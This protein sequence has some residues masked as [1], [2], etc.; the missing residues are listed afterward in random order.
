MG[1]SHFKTQKSVREVDRHAM[2]Y[3]CHGTTLDGWLSRHPA[4]RAFFPSHLANIAFIDDHDN[5]RSDGDFLIGYSLSEIL[6]AYSANSL[7]SFSAY[8][9]SCCTVFWSAF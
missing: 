5:V 1:F 2:K 6:Y 4:I 9:D 3:L 7:G 8:S